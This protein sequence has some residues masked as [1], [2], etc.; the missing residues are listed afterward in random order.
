MLTSNFLEA[1]L[2][3]KNTALGSDST[4]SFK[5]IDSAVTNCISVDSSEKPSGREEKLEMMDREME[6]KK[7]MQAL[8]F[9]IQELRKK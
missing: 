3:R 6:T 1:P 7:K 4:I 9:K 8:V 2:K 5:R